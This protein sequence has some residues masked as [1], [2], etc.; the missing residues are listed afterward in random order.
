MSSFSATI[1]RITES[2]RW[3]KTSSEWALPVAATLATA[4]AVSLILR[5]SEGYSG[6]RPPIV[7]SWIPWVGSSW[8]IEKDPDAF[9]RQAEKDFPGGIIGVHSAGHKFYFVTSSSLINQIYKQPKV[10][11]LSPVQ[12]GWA[13]AVFSLSDHALFGSTAFPERL[14]PHMSRSIAPKNM[15]GLINSFENHLRQEV[16]SRAVPPQSVSLQEFVIKLSYI[17]TGAAYFG[18]TFNAMGT[19]DAFK[20][21]DEM[22]YKVALG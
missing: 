21:F 13:K 19:W 15:M 14:A 6:D 2:E 12:M 8:E 20:G 1:T 17:A 7:S 10:Y 3:P 11:T 22:V 9:F 16:Q 18:P 4:V 5:P